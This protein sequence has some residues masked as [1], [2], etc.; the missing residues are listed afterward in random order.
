MGDMANLATLV[1]VDSFTH[2]V[3]M[4]LEVNQPPTV[5]CLLLRQL[6]AR[7]DCLEYTHW[8]LLLPIVHD[9]MAN[10]SP[11]ERV[12]LTSSFNGLLDELEDLIQELEGIAEVTYDFGRNTF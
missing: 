10:G 11:L 3:F 6:V 1:V 8:H 2:G 5:I 9:R 4:G 12:A 7:Q